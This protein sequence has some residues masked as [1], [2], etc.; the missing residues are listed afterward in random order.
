MPDLSG[1][2]L[3]AEYYFVNQVL[4]VCV[5]VCV[6]DGMQYRLLAWRDALHQLEHCWP[7]VKVQTV[8]TCWPI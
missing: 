6:W 4:L 3:C 7:E 8:S 2:L 1:K 5:C